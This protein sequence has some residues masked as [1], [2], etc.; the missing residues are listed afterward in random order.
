MRLYPETLAGQLQQKLL[1]VYLI[2]GDETL[3]VQECCD[4]IRQ[5]ARQDGCSEREIIDAGVSS[6]NWQDIL[7]S[8][9]SMSL[10]AERKLIE[11][12]LPSGK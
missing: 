12:R 9:S 7:H 6:F 5:K 2:S 1:R 10:F 8:A 3:L 11:L 4:L